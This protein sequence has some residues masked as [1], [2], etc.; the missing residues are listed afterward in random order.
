M[1]RD[2]LPFYY[3]MTI[4]VKHSV[5]PDYLA[6]ER[7]YYTSKNKHC[8]FLEIAK[9]WDSFFTCFRDFLKFILPE[10]LPVRFDKMKEKYY[11]SA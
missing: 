1:S 8:E 4:K 5:R 7:K 6:L 10:L 2:I 3:D 9:V 11:P